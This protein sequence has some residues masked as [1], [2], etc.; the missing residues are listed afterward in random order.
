MST[1]NT[2]QPL[3]ELLNERVGEL[4]TLIGCKI[5]EPF[6][7][8][9]ISQQI[10][11]LKDLALKAASQLSQEIKKLLEEGNALCDL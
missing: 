10:L 9:S 6:T 3:I 7:T 5:K 4:E 1:P 8:E 2:K 11:Q